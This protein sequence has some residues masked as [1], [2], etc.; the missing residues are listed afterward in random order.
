MREIRSVPPVSSHDL[1]GKELLR[2]SRSYYESFAMVARGDSEN[3]LKPYH[4]RSDVGT[5]LSFRHG[6]S[7]TVQL[8][9]PDD[10]YCHRLSGR[11]R[12]VAQHLP[13]LV[14][15]RDVDAHAQPEP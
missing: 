10:T 3:C 15:D 9:Q 13:V 12:A 2:L 7:G 4:R 14:A 11:R 1:A 8:P 5:R 6:Q